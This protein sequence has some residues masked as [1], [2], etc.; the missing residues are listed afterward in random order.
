[1]HQNV[2]TKPLDKRNPKNATDSIPFIPKGALMHTK[3]GT[4]A[5]P[6]STIKTLH[7]RMAPG[8]GFEP[9]GAKRTDLAGQLLTRLGNPGKQ[10]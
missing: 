10:P 4:N 6:K 7:A 5:Y 8:E 3:R 1:M 9:S 2:K